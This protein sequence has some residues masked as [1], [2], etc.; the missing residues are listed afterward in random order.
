MSKKTGNNIRLGI[1]VSAGIALLIGG[2]YFIGEKQQLFNTTF[3][4]NAIFKDINGLQVGNNVRFAG[5]NVG[6]VDGINQVT[7]STV[8]VEMIIDEKTKKFMKKNVKAL[9]SSD[10]LMGSKIIIILPSPGGKAEIANY[11]RIETTHAV[12][13]DD[14]LVK[15]KV[16]GDNAANITDNLSAIMQNIRDGKGT[17]GKLFMDSTFALTLDQTLVNIKQGAGGFKE[18]M[19]AAKSNFLFRGFFKKK[20]RD[21]ERNKDKDKDKNKNKNN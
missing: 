2:L 7:D 21:K 3:H 12:S 4:I 16:A 6:I 14:I 17:I 8:Q 20:K 13:V 15:L 11:D 18:N 1:F 9:I 5:I 19:T 10:G